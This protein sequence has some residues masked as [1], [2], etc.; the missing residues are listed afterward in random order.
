VNG[1]TRVWDGAMGIDNGS[2]KRDHGIS[3]IG[4]NGTLV[5]DRSGWEVIE[6]RQSKNKVL[7]PLQKSS[8]NGVELHWENFIN[9]IR[10]NKSES[11]NCSIEEG[12]HIATVAQMG[13]I[14]YRS[15][16]KVSWDEAKQSFTDEAVQE[17]YHT[18]KYNNGYTI[19][20]L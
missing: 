2:Y 9:A 15:G 13:N 1:L 18:K 10:T 8:D 19:P 3:F 4:N 5:L 11:L 16:K 17:E 12:A 7:M 20:K 14:A 6:E